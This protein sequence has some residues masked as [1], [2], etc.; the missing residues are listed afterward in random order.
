MASARS[1]AARV[2]DVINRTEKLETRIEFALKEQK[3]G[4]CSDLNSTALESVH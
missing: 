4:I 1:M 3:D 2:T